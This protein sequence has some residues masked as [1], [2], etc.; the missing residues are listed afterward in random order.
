MSIL[1]Q[2]FNK[3]VYYSLIWKRLAWL[4]GILSLALLCFLLLPT[5]PAQARGPQSNIIDYDDFR[6]TAT[7][8]VSPNIIFLVVDD[9]GY[10]DL[11]FLGGEA[12]TPNLDDLANGGMMLT[13]FHTLPSCTPARAALLTGVDNH[14]NGVGTM[15]VNLLRPPGSTHQAGHPGYEGFMNNHVTSVAKILQNNGYNT[16]MIGK[17]HL[18]ED[19]EGEYWPLKRGFDRFFGTLDGGSDHYGTKIDDPFF[20]KTR[21]ISQSSH[22]TPVTSTFYSSKDYTDKLIQFITNNEG[23]DD[24]FFAYAA[25]T[26]PHWPLQVPVTYTYKY[27]TGDPLS[28]TISNVYTYS[29]GWDVVRQKRF[30]TWKT[31]GLVSGDMPTSWN[32]NP[33]ADLTSSEQLTY[34]KDMAIYAGM[35]DYLD[36]QIGRLIDT[37]KA[38]DKYTNT[39]IIFLSDNGADISNNEQ[40]RAYQ[41]YYRRTGIDNSYDNRGLYYSF[42]TY[43]PSWGEVS[44]TPLYAGKTTV[45]EGGIR[46]AAFIHYPDGDIPDDGRRHSGFNTVFDLTP[47]ALDYAGIAHPAG[48]RQGTIRPASHEDFFCYDP[49]TGHDG[50]T[51]EPM[52]GKSL[53]S[54]WENGTLT[55]RAYSEYE[56]VG[57]ELYGAINKAL[58]MGDWKIVRVGSDRFAPSSGEWE[59]FNIVDDPGEQTNRASE[60]PVQ[61]QTMKDLYARYEV[62]VGFV[63]IY[64]DV[65][66]PI[67]M[68]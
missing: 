47:T 15:P 13:N 8:P 36:E 43:N 49:G 26:A 65:M 61:L 33:W 32:N 37:L 16:Y 55:D 48:D 64:D 67:I 30:D 29:V 27:M 2:K 6:V 66:L 22:I 31:L 1:N 50:S 41:N 63:D 68:K 28:D 39:L 17:W 24:P 5:S 11:G 52:N 60:Y 40:S 58:I 51:C 9:M 12:Q 7:A 53:R 62:D 57:F 54:E 46:T 44:N 18:G 25:Y 19:E 34:T 38:E 42:I 35:L 59:L 20:T 4:A 45:Y 21:F 3:N 14:I 23:N 56:P 10:S